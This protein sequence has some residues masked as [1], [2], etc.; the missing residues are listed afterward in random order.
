ML[1]SNIKIN[2]GIILKV[3]K[4]F[5]GIKRESISYTKIEENQFKD[6][7]IHY[8]CAE[9]INK[10]RFI[11]IRYPY[12]WHFRTCYNSYYQAPEDILR[13]CCSYVGRIYQNIKF[14]NRHELKEI[15][16]QKL[17]TETVCEEM[18]QPV[19]GIN[20]PV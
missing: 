5:I 11:E 6:A 13:E 18:Y 4:S 9:Y 15:L 16:E 14:G 3:E 19:K 17:Y 8:D 7:L 12:E 1:D 20:E 10:G 2:Q